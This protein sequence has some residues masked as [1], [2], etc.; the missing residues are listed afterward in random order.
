[1]GICPRKKHQGRQFA[2]PSVLLNI[3]AGPLV[4][5]RPDEHA[6]REVLTWDDPAGTVFGT[7]SAKR[8]SAGRPGYD[9]LQRREAAVE[10]QRGKR[11]AP[12]ERTSYSPPSTSILTSCGMGPPLAMKSSSAIAETCITPRLPRTGCCPSV[13]TPPCDLRVPPRQKGM[14]LA[15]YDYT[16][17]R[18]AGMPPDDA[19]QLEQN[20]IEYVRARKSK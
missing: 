20:Q 15:V 9:A 2:L 4:L 8:Q 10:L 5:F 11:L 1:M 13:S 17:E 19:K 12:T 14:S 16:A 18:P 6:A 7:P 3:Q